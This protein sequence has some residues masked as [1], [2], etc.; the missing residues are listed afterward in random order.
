MNPTHIESAGGFQAGR[1]FVFDELSSTN[2]WSLNQGDTGTHGDTAWCQRQTA[3]RGRRGRHWHAPGELGLT[4]SARIAQESLTEHLPLGLFGLAGALAVRESLKHFGITSHA[5]WPNDV[6]VNERKICGILA[7]RRGLSNVLVLGVGLNVNTA[8]KDW[9]KQA[10]QT[11]PTSMSMESGG[12]QFI[13]RDVLNVVLT[14]LNTTFSLSGKSVISAWRKQDQWVNKSVKV[15]Q[16]ESSVT[17]CYLGIDDDGCARLRL[18]DGSEQCIVAG[19]IS[20]RH[21]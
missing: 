20:L 18:A 19:D 13:I 16:A 11:P 8:S 6:W 7:E 1:L 15:C 2:E 9:G 14:S 5:K 17:G 3:G 12:E 10:Y 4:F 21:E